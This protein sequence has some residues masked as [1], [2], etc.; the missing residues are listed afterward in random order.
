MYI[1]ANELIEN[2]K[3]DVYAQNSSNFEELVISDMT[4]NQFVEILEL[5]HEKRVSNAIKTLN[6]AHN[7]LTALP[8]SIG[9]LAGL[10]ELYVNDNQLTALPES[11]GNFV[12]LRVLHVRGNRLTALPESIGNLVGLT[13]FSVTDNQLTA[14]PESIGNLVGLSDLYVYD[15]QLTAL[16]ESI[17]NLR[18]LEYL[19]LADNRLTDGSPS[20]PREFQAEW[21][22]LQD[23]YRLDV[24]LSAAGLNDFI[25]SDLSSIVRD[26]VLDST[27]K[28]LS[29]M[30][31]NILRNSVDGITTASITSSS[32][33]GSSSSSPSSSSSSS[34]FSSSLHAY[35]RNIEMKEQKE[36][37]GN[38]TA[39]TE[40]LIP[41]TEEAQIELAIANSLRD[42]KSRNQFNDGFSCSSSSSALLF[43]LRN[44]SDVL[45]VAT[46]TTTA[47]LS[48]TPVAPT[49]QQ[50]RDTQLVALRKSGL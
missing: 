26:Y 25:L 12:G 10:R 17:G 24:S 37:R 20:T 47:G 38:Y 46:T 36:E 5:L 35:D 32:L 15:N 4:D 44:D 8:E 34:S 7:Q 41:N 39:H 43:S 22:K 31:R 1:T 42:A 9:N 28:T 30:T 49:E 29:P 3:N 18:G 40:Q 48:N 13:R 27:Y 21:G 45:A 33:S 6:V 2:L 50:R 16:P 11:I 14:L 19:H 23:A